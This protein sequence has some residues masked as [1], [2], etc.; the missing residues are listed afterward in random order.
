MKKKRIL[1][2]LFALPFIGLSQNASEVA[3]DTLYR[4]DQI[5]FGVTYNT[6]IDTPEVY[7][8]TNFSPGFKAGFIRDF[9]INKKRNIAFGLGFGY[10][11]N[12]SAQNLKITP[13]VNGSFDYEF[14]SGQN[15]QKNRF[16]YQAIEIPFE[17]RWRT[18]TAQ[19]NKFWRIY[20]GFKASYVFASR[21]FFK[22]NNE[23]RIYKDL[24]LNPWQYGLTL[25]AGYNNWNAFIYYG[26]NS[27]FE[28][29]S[30][31]QNPLEMK[32]LKVGLMFYIL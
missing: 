13:T 21:T 32:S 26:L 10:A 30:I 28:T 8:Q 20:T 7:T 23:T 5:Y 3:I 12:I 31:N 18:S 4:E 1:I 25:S 2:L 14:L 6:L 9:P 15:Y 17:F 16:S 29:A 19:S 24:E 11:L 22:A 27:I